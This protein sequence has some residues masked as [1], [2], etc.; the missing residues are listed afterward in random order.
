LNSL[1][2]NAI[3]VPLLN[4]ET[5]ILNYEKLLKLVHIQGDKMSKLVKC[6]ECGHEISKSA[7]ACPNCGAKQKKTGFFTKVFLFFGFLW[8]VGTFMTILG[9]GSG[10]SSSN[11]NSSKKAATFKPN[12]KN[13]GKT[14]VHYA[15]EKT[16]QWSELLGE[17]KKCA[18]KNPKDKEMKKMVARYQKKLKEYTKKITARKK[19]EKKFGK[20]PIKSAWDGTVKPVERY[21]KRVARNPASIDVSACTDVRIDQKKGWIVGCDFRGENGF[22][23]K[24]LESKW[25]IIKHGQVIK[26]LDSNAYKL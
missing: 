3:Q 17:A 23:G 19:L 7:K 5:I 16:G 13:F 25:F 6:K 12:C 11:S 14:I 21:L 10:A 1:L 4:N 22:G 2:L 20:A 15:P 8:I 18:A 24:T 9:G 26:M